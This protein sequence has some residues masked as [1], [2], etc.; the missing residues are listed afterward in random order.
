MTT[1]RRHLLHDKAEVALLRRGR[2]RSGHPPC[3]CVHDVPTPSLQ[4]AVLEKRK[5]RP[6]RQTELDS[7]VNQ[8]QKTKEQ[9]SA[10]ESRRGQAQQEDDEAKKQG[11]DAS[12]KLEES[13]CQLVEL[14]AAKE[15]RLQELRK[16]QQERDRTW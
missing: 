1:E 2:A 6:S 11:Q 12:S 4:A 14:S 10:S 7:K 15:T 8:L 16:I 9:L 5:K 13:Q 3:R